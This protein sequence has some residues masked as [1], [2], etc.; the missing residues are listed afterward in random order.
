MCARL[1]GSKAPRARKNASSNAPGGPAAPP[2]AK[3]GGNQRVKNLRKG[4]V[5]GRAS[6]SRSALSSRPRVNAPR[7]VEVIERVILFAD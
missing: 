4:A 1:L 2:N 6:A 7:G 5:C 3:Q